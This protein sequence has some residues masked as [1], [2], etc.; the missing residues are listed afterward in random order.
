[1]SI[2]TMVDLF[3]SFGHLVLAQVLLLL[4]ILEES[5]CPTFFCWVACIGDGS[6]NADPTTRDYLRHPTEV[7]FASR[8]RQ[9]DISQKKV[10]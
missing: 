6:S 3:C 8:G 9:L 1:M 4:Y 5:L 2:F 7:V 10:L